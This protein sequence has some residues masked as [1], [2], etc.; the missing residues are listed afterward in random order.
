MPF[1]YSQYLRGD[2]TTGGGRGSLSRINAHPSPH[3]SARPSHSSDDPPGPPPGPPILK[4]AI[5]PITGLRRPSPRKLV[6]VKPHWRYRPLKPLPRRQ[7]VVHF[8]KIE[9]QPFHFDWSCADDVF[10]SRAELAAMGSDRF[11]DADTLRR[12]RQKDAGGDATPAA[13]D[14]AEIAA[15]PKTV[16]VAAILTSALQDPDEDEDVSIR[17]IEH[18]VYR[19]LQQ[20]MLRRKKQVQ[21]EVLE[22]SRSRKLD[23]RGWRLAEHSRRLTE[24]ARNVATE[25]GAQDRRRLAE[26]E[27]AARALSQSERTRFVKSQDEMD[28]QLRASMGCASCGD[29]R[30]ASLGDQRGAARAAAP[31]LLQ[32]PGAAT[33]EA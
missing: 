7:K 9:V 5:N 15:K 20:E 21:R 31:S 2:K 30:M 25:K 18:F 13:A 10:L 29:L 28:Q 12:R 24:W 3:V 11:D 32:P 33:G 19:D 1:F 27:P 22:F 14:D 8:D 6:H 17:G 26:S 23:P 4:A 16:D